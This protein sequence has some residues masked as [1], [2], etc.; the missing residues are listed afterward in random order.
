MRSG[1]FALRV[2]MSGLTSGRSHAGL[3]LTSQL[4]IG[5]C[6]LQVRDRSQPVLCAA[7][8]R[9]SKAGRQ[10]VVMSKFDFWRLTA[11]KQIPVI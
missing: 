1:F 4:V 3:Q 8:F 11:Q 5:Y 9:L 6:P 7:L 10:V 2:L